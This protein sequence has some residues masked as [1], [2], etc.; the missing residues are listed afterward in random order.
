MRH[1]TGIAFFLIAALPYV[2]MVF[3]GRGTGPRGQADDTLAVISPHR[4]EVRLEYSRGFAEWMRQHHGRNVDIQWLDVGGTSKVLKELGS[5]FEAD[6]DRPGVDLMFGGGVAPFYRAID[7]GWLAAVDLPDAHLEGIPARVA[8]TPVFDPDKR[9]FGVALSGF[10][11]LYNKP[12]VERMHLPAPVS[13]DDLARPEFFTWLASGDPRSSGSVHM[14]YEIILQAYG[15]EQGWSLITRLCANVRRFG[16]GGGVAPR[17]VASGDVAAGMVIDQ[18]AQTVIDSVGGDALVFVLP[19]G[20][21]VINA[22]PIAMLRGADKPELARLFVTYVLSRD[23]QRLLYQ[24]AGTDGQRH[25]LHRMPVLAPLYDEAGAPPTRPYEVEAGFQY[26]SDKGGKRWRLVNDL[27]G[28]WLIDAHG[29]L[30]KAWQAV[31][32]AGSPPALVDRLC[33]A[34]GDEEEMI[35]MA[36]QWSDSRY[37]LA[38][39]NAWAHAARER[40]RGV[41]ETARRYHSDTRRQARWTPAS[42]RRQYLAS[43]SLAPDRVQRPRSTLEGEDEEH[44][45]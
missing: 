26:D 29:D 24:P 8:G 9:W 18:Y 37:R 39:V 34:P 38:Q 3:T 1:A 7:H 15:F 25:S 5:R 43:T 28:V 4:R 45:L 20:A 41:A 35:R 31:I 27:I 23:G 33:A 10:G 36:E 12:L 32:A 21:T 11:I 19:E 17:E 40:Y 44:S 6:S 22:D 16:E 30:V 14:C 2:A 13:W 42:G